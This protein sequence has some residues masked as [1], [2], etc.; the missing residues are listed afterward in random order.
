[1]SWF[2]EQMR[3]HIGK[4]ASID[5]PENVL[6]FPRRALGSSGHDASEALELV[7]QAAEVIRGIEDRAAETEARAKALAQ[8]AIEQLHLAEAQV[9]S[10]EAAR[11][12]AEERLHMVGAKLEKAEKELMRTESRVAAAEARLANAEQRVRAA[13]TRAIDAEKALTQIED[14][15]RSQLIGLTR[16]LARPTVAA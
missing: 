8:S 7:S 4:S 12:G 2:Q 6:N 16:D 9:Q 1:M 11:R 5:S 13:A 15:I 10:A 3:G 14:A